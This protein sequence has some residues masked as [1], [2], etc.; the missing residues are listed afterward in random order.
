[1]AL[2]L[3]TAIAVHAADSQKST[4]NKAG[5]QAQATIERVDSQ[6]DKITVQ[7]LDKEGRATEKTLDLKGRRHS[8]H[9]RH[10]CK[11]Q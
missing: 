9:P 4:S 5:N 8:R 6:S 7:K 10:D 3:L 11:A 2:G 1:M